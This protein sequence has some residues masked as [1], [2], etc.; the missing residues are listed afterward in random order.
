MRN[1]N[2]IHANKLLYKAKASFT[3]CAEAEIFI[4][5]L[6]TSFIKGKFSS[7]F[8]FFLS[9][10]ISAIKI[11]ISFSEKD[12]SVQCFLKNRKA[13]IAI[14][15]DVSVKILPKHNSTHMPI[16]IASPCDKMVFLSKK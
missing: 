7:P 8:L 3:S 9:C 11:S 6:G 12:R 15:G 5:G 4:N 10:C 1:Y 16:A 2:R 14:L 13:S